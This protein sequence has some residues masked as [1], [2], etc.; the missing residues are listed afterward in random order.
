MFVEVKDKGNTVGMI[1]L[2][3]GIGVVLPWNAVSTCFDFFSAEMPGYQPA[4]I[5]PFAVNILNAT[6]QFVICIYGP[7][8]PDRLKVQIAFFMQAVVLILLPFV[9]HY[10]EDPGTKFY[11]CFALL[12]VFG[13]FNGMSQGQ[14]FGL[15][16]LL[17]QKYLGLI[18]LGNGICGVGLNLIRILCVV[19]LPGNDLYRQSLI[20]FILS[21]VIIFICTWAYSVLNR[22]QFYKHHRELSRNKD[23]RHVDLRATLQMFTMKDQEEFIHHPSE[24]GRKEIM[25]RKKID[26][27]MRKKH[28]AGAF[29]KLVVQVF[30]QAWPVFMSIWLC[31]TVTFSLLP[32]AFYLS[33]LKMFS[34]L[35]DNEYTVYTLT[36]IVIFNIFDTIGRQVG[37]FLHVSAGCCYLIAIVRVGLVATTILIATME[38]SDGN[39]IETDAFKLANIGFFSITNG[40]ISTQLAIKAPRFVKEEQREQAGILIGLHIAA[41]ILTGSILAIPV[42]KFVPNLYWE[43]VKYN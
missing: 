2:L 24:E 20:F 30:K 12:L 31:Y 15:G 35:G 11:A 34:T 1:F 32:G 23:Q 38:Y 21:A 39:I 8:M 3:W 27:L 29:C 7:S 16:G 43:S 13:G 6:M 18:M 5:Y 40:F 41:G 19:M 25:K 42:G 17:P 10:I 4:F 14:V 36:M 22:N 28:S 33:H 9:T 26:K 37:G